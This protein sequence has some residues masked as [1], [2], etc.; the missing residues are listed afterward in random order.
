MPWPD[1]CEALEQAVAAEIAGAILDVAI[2][3]CRIGAHGVRR[4]YDKLAQHMR[5]VERRVRDAQSEAA[6]DRHEESLDFW[7]EQ[8]DRCAERKRKYWGPYRQD[9]E[10][11]NRRYGLPHGSMHTQLPWQALHDGERPPPLPPAPSLL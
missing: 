8:L 7:R 9:R 1:W 5:E 3:R 2:A 4:E 6:R 10:W 11:Q